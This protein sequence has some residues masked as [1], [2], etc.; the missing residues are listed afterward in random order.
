MFVFEGR[1]FRRGV[2]SPS[3]TGDTF[4][5]GMV[6][7]LGSGAAPPAAL[8]FACALAGAKC[9]VSG[10]EV[11]GIPDLLASLPVPAPPPA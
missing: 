10:F 1:A 7:A 6:F 9:G 2:P 4:L 5:A 3:L 11:P 8:A